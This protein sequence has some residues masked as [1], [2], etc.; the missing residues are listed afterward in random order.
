[1]TAAEVQA[2]QRFIRRFYTQ[3]GRHQLPWRLTTDPYAITVSE[4]MLQQTQVARV[5]EYFKRFMTQFPDWESLAKA[6]ESAVIRAWQG[7]GYNRRGLFLQRAAREVI[8]QFNGQLP[9]SYDELTSLPGIGPYTATAI[10]AFAFNSPSIVI[11]TNV[12]TVFLHHF[13]PTSE[14]VSDAQLKGLISLT[15]DQ[16]HPRAWYAALMDYGTYLKSILPNP[17]RRSRHY[18]RQSPL[19][20]SNREVRGQILTYFS[21]H[22]AATVQQ[23]SE[24][25]LFN[26]ERVQPALA[27]LVSEGFLRFHPGSRIYRLI[28]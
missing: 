16:K 9:S 5:I 19:R 2:F 25:L 6:P 12:R 28:D 21:T 1:M 8:K 24:A 26:T 18:T 22:D 20:G 15:M 10:Q 4:I 7:L 23:L 13:F 3:Y 27:Q 17:S 11:E 14:A